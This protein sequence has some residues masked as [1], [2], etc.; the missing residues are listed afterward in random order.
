LNVSGLATSGMMINGALLSGILSQAGKI[1]LSG[2]SYELNGIEKSEGNDTKQ[3]KLV[4]DNNEI[5][6][7][8]IG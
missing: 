6:S 4:I 7:K 8:Y 1:S 2:G 5:K 3:W